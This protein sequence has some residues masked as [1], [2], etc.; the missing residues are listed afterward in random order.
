MSHIDYVISD[1][2]MDMDME[3][4]LDKNHSDINKNT[5]YIKAV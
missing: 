1:M 5:K 2:D 3:E 4:Y